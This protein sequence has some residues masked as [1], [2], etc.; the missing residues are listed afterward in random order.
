V[1]SLGC[2]VVNKWAHGFPLAHYMKIVSTRR[3]LMRVVPVSIYALL[4]V[5]R[6]MR[7]TA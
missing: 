5:S 2:D 4:S 6:R 7:W 3:L 1:Q